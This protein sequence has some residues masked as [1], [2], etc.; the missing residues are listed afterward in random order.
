MNWEVWIPLLIAVSAWIP[1]IIDWLANRNQSSAAFYNA[2]MEGGTKAVAAATRLN[3]EYQEQVKELRGEIEAIK[4]ARR[5]REIETQ[6]ERDE[7]QARIKAEL[8]ETRNMRADYLEHKKEVADLRARQANDLKETIELRA[9]VAALRA[10]NL[11]AKNVIK[12]LL[13]FF[14]DNKYDVPELNGDL[15]KLGE[16]VRGLVV[17][18]PK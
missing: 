2:M 13:Q 10:E 7:L 3:D 11:A 12:K 15:D 1:K 8:I 16:S 17:R 18:K 5:L 4:E 9:D 14:I 6:N